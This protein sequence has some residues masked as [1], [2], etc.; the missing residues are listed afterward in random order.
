M[1]ALLKISLFIL[2]LFPVHSN[3]QEIEMPS[4]CSAFAPSL[5]LGNSLS[6]NDVDSISVDNLWGQTEASTQKYWIVFSADNNIPVRSQPYEYASIVSRLNISVKMRIAEIKNNYALLYKENAPGSVSYPQI[7]GKAEPI[8]WVSMHDLLL[9]Q[10]CPLAKNGI[11]RKAFVDAEVLARILEKQKRECHFQKQSSQGFDTYMYFVIKEAGDSI[12]LA[13]TPELTGQVEDELIGWAMRY[14]VMFWDTRACIEP[15]WNASTVDSL[16]AAG[17]NLD[18][19]ESGNISRPLC[20]FR[21]GSKDKKG[22]YRLP[23]NVFRMPLIEEPLPGSVYYKCA[24]L[25]K[26]RRPFDNTDYVYGK[27]VFVNI[28][29]SD[30]LDV[31]RKCIII[32]TNEL[33]DVAKRVSPLIDLA[34]STDGNLEDRQAFV[35]KYSDLGDVYGKCEPLSPAMLNLADTDYVSTEDFLDTVHS[36]R[37]KCEKLQRLTRSTYKYSFKIGSLNYYIIPIDELP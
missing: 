26:L 7:S 25:N 24:L 1:K 20:S 9:W 15:N 32:S 14:D 17:E 18:I 35:A 2:A 19:F 12:L 36:F 6:V 37:D 23:A 27:Q 11:Y 33:A 3:A 5:L 16:V 4:T 34:N 10:N 29:S 13:R 31:C 8:G 30:S 22:N 21:F 28:K